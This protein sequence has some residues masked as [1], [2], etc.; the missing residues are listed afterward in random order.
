VVRQYGDPW[1]LEVDAVDICLP[2][3]LHAEVALAALAQ[4]RHVLVEKPVAP[5]RTGFWLRQE[6]TTG[7]VAATQALRRPSTKRCSM[8]R[9][10]KR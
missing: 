3:D 1:A 6:T 10:L 8:R 7:G 9:R 4:G 5:G 2:H